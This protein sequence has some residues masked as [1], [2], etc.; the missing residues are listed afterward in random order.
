MRLA[1]LA[2]LL[3]GVVLGPALAA[4]H[5]HPASALLAVAKTGKER[6]SDEGSDEQRVDGCKVPQARRTRARQTACL[7]DVGA[8]LHVLL[9]MLGAKGDRC[10]APEHGGPAACQRH[11]AVEG[12]I[13]TGARV[14]SGFQSSGADVSHV[15]QI[16]TARGLAAHKP[17]PARAFDFSTRIGVCLSSLRPTLHAR[18]SGRAVVPRPLSAT[19]GSRRD[20]PCSATKETRLI[21]AAGSRICTRRP[22]ATAGTPAGCRRR[23]GCRGEPIGPEARR[24]WPAMPSAFTR[25]APERRPPLS[26]TSDNLR[27]KPS[28]PR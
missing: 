28:C 24:R 14:S 19:A 7:W 15:D 13:A 4:D 18:P 9:T 2:A 21:Q 16:W 12:Q 26:P 10:A 3:A 6:L 20:P 11:D 8:S 22:A 1:L 17:D 23:T 25:L 27:R 5:D